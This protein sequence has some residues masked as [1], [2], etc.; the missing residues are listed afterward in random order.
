[1][2]LI[3]EPGA[4]VNV[5]DGLTVTFLA[6]NEGPLYVPDKIT[7][8]DVAGPVPLLQ[9]LPFHTTGMMLFTSKETLLDVAVL[10]VTQPP[11]MASSANTVVVAPAGKE[12]EPA[13]AVYVSEEDAACSVVAAFL[14]M[15]DNVPPPVLDATAVRV[16]FV[17]TFTGPAAS[18]ESVNEGVSLAF[19]VK[20][21]V[22]DVVPQKPPLVVRVRVT[23][24][25]ELAA[26]V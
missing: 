17:S 18:E 14:K 22:L 24:L 10:L 11:E 12:A 7:M 8:S 3:T 15:Y 4:T 21:L 19:T 25:D 26:A 6:V 1:M 20:L 13:T 16:T 9:V 2:A 23:G 5:V